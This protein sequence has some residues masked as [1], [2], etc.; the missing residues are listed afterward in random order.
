M[1]FF[2]F[3]LFMFHVSAPILCVCVCVCGYHEVWI[4]YLIDKVVL[5]RTIVSFSADSIL[6]SC[7]YIGLSFPSS[8][9]CSYCHKLSFFI[10]WVHY[11]R[12]YSY[13]K[14]FSPFKLYTILFNSILIQSSNFSDSVYSSP[15][16]KF[17]VL[18][19][20]C[21]RFKSSLQHFL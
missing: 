14:Y 13:F 11:Q 3:L 20:F 10:S 7:I 1:V 18:L 17:C 21:F 8:L 4:K 12:S 5:F 2:C 15:Y 9:P 19:P 6:S 16:S